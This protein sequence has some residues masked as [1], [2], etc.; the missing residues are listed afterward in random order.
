MRDAY[1]GDLLSLWNLGAVEY[2]PN[3]PVDAGLGAEADKK[4]KSRSE[5]FRVIRDVV[6]L[7]SQDY[8]LIC[9]L[10]GIDVRWPR[11]ADLGELILMGD[12]AM[13][14]LYNM[15]YQLYRAEYQLQHGREQSKRRRKS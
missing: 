3:I 14:I 8:E 4:L 13:R 10:G 6:L 12:Q 2:R 15:N 9:D 11:A 7:E 5:I 1:W